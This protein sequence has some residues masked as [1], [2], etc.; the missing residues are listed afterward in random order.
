LVVCEFVLGGG[1]H[2]E[3]GVSPLAVVEDLEV[4]ENMALASSTRVRQRRRLRS[5]VCIL[6]QNDSMTALMLL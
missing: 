2:A 6:P 3:G 4:F 1:E 5:S